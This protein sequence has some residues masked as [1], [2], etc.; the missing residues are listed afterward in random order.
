MYAA[1]VG[2]REMVDL[3]LFHHAQGLAEGA[4]AS[5]KRKAIRWKM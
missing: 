4:V 5:I 3:I 2:R 1:V